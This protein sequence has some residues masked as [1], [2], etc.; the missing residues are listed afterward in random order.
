MHTEYI[1]LIA[2]YYTVLKIPKPFSR[3][4]H[5]EAWVRS[6]RVRC[7]GAMGDEEDGH[8]EAEDI[9]SRLECEFCNVTL[10]L[11]LSHFTV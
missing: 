4:S 1:N 7:P 2:L 8:R 9:R 11:T 10:P 3:R 5:R 6:G